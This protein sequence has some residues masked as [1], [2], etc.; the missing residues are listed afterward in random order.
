MACFDKV[1]QNIAKKRRREAK[2]IMEGSLR[3]DLVGEGLAASRVQL[4]LVIEYGEILAFGTWLS[5]QTQFD[6]KD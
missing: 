1:V 5:E 2:V 3:K 6:D 4:K